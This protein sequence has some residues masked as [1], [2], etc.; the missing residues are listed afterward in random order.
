[1]SAST[2]I[3]EQVPCTN[4]PIPISR[5][6]NGRSRS[7][8]NSVL[9]SRRRPTCGSI[10]RGSAKEIGLDAEQCLCSSMIAASGMRASIC[11]RILATFLAR[12][13]LT[14]FRAEASAR[15]GGW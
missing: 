8:L 2:H 4:V 10:Y 15:A 7:C 14:E 11:S 6:V 9:A 13:A 1:M 3:E 5:R 12:Y